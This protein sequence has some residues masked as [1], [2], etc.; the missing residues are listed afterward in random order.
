VTVPVTAVVQHWTYRSTTVCG[1]P[2][3][4][5]TPTASRVTCPICLLEV[6]M[7]LDTARR[8]HRLIRPAT[9]RPVPSGM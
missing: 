1:E 5:R 2:T 8:T 4:P 7:R 6:H 3:G 9:R